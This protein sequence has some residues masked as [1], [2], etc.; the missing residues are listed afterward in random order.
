MVMFE[1]LTTIKSSKNSLLNYQKF[2]LS[3]SDGSKEII[4]KPSDFPSFVILNHSQNSI[5]YHKS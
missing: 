5:H 3:I 4:G 2:L 1:V